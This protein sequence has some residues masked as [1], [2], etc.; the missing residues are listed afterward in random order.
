VVDL[1]EVMETSSSL[2]AQHHTS[3]KSAMQRCP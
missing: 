2:P 1:V 3:A